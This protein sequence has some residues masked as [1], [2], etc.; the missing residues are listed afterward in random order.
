MN[1]IKINDRSFRVSITETEIKADIKDA[2]TIIVAVDIN[3]EIITDKEITE[4]SEIIMRHKEADL[5]KDVRSLIKDRIN[6]RDH[7]LYL[8]SN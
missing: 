8:R 5:S 2:I 7:Y 3:K 6:N 1:S 4:D